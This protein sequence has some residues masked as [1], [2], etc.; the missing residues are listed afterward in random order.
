MTTGSLSSQGHFQKVPHVFS[1]SNSEEEEIE[2]EVHQ[3]EPFYSVPYQH[4]K[5]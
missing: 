2:D 3:E 1:V 4:R 5:K